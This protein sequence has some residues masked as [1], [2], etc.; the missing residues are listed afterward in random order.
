MAQM[1]HDTVPSDI[2]D[3]IEFDAACRLAGA[4]VE[5]VGEPPLEQD[6]ERGPR[7]IGDY[8]VDRKLGTGGSGTVYHA[9]L[10]GW[11]DEFAIKLLHEP[12]GEGRSTRRA[13]RE[14]DMVEELDLPDM[15]RVF[16]YGVHDGRMFIVSEHV[17]GRP[18]DEFCRAEHRDLRDTVALLV[19][20]ALAVHALNE[21]GVIHRDLKPSN[22]LV[23]PA[24]DPVIIDLGIAALAHD[25]PTRTR[26][27]AGTQLGSV[28]FMAPEQARGE[29]ATIQSDVYGLGATAVRILTGATPHDLRDMTVLEA[30]Q[31][32]AHEPSRDLRSLSPKLPEPV[33]AVLDKALA[34]RADDRYSSVAEFAHDLE[35]WLAGRPVSAQRPSW[36]RDRWLSIKREPSRWAWGT[37]A[38]VAIV[39][40]AIFGATSFASA[41]GYK[42]GRSDGW[43][44]IIVNSSNRFV[45][46]LHDGDFKQAFMML[47]MLED[48]A[49]EAHKV[50]IVVPESAETVARHRDELTRGALWAIHGRGAEDASKRSLAMAALRSLYEP[51]GAWD[52]G[53]RLLFEEL[54]KINDPG[55]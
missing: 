39:G 6:D 1:N 40:L 24:G 18:L 43:D 49:E 20:V 25:D 11:N 4:I 48:Y 29:R 52:E 14:L 26:T 22:I 31:K 44:E 30:L 23:T 51:E 3:A 33:A 36:W 21:R 54:L 32:V 8:V 13:W 35:H 53:T 9:V 12:V 46:R 5:T 15:P 7:R 10:P 38:C 55:E 16:D 28:A 34:T 45:E 50:S 17:A 42:A 19:R 37:A 41:S 2:P 27:V 47:E